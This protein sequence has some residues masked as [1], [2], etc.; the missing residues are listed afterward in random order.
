MADIPLSSALSGSTPR[1]QIVTLTASNASLPI[2]SWAQG[3]KGIVYVTGCGGGGSGGV[4][5]D[6]GTRGGGGASAM[7]VVA[8]PFVIPAGITTLSVVIGAG[9][10]G[11]SATAQAAGNAGGQTSLNIGNAISLV[12]DGGAGGS[13]DLAGGA[14]AN[15]AATINRAE[16][17][18]TAGISPSATGAFAASQV[19][20]I[21]ASQGQS[22][23]ANPGFGAGGGG[24]FG[25]GGA[26]IAV[27]PTANT[28]GANG[29][30]YGSGGAGA[31]WLAGG[32]AKAGDGGPGLL[33]LEFVEGF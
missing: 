31:L 15:L 6:S 18:T 19:T 3:G 27:A 8:L 33:I 2:P 32:A 16:N 28:D 23:N 9:G 30:G 11:P 4:R 22:G 25:R 29:N 7:S 13:G 1:R 14:V 20:I 26:G 12:I 10:A 24:M 21:G 17:S 5:A